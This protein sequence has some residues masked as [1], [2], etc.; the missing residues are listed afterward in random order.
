MKIVLGFSFGHRGIEPG[1]SNEMLARVINGLTPAVISVQW[2]IG[3]MLHRLGTTTHHEVSMHRKV[4]CYLDTE[5]V[6]RQMID[7]LQKSHLTDKTLYVVAHPAHLPRC[8]RILRKLGVTTVN[9]IKADIPYDPA[10]YQIWTRS[11]LL[12]HIREIL[13]FPIYLF[14][15]YYTA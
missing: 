12:F 15:G 3:I 9:P 4:G 10:S 13:A 1:L 5:E 14:R 8:V 11:P 2:E 7:F 6:A